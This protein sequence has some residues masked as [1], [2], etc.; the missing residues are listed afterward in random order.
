MNILSVP[1]RLVASPEG[2]QKVPNYLLETER[3]VKLKDNDTFEVEPAV[4]HFSGIKINNTHVQKLRIINR[5]GTQKRVIIVPPETPY[6]SIKY[7]KKTTLRPGLSED[8][9]IEFTPTEYKYYGDSI[10]LFCYGDNNLLIPIHGY[11]SVNNIQF[12]SRV[13]FHNVAISRSITKSIPLSCDIPVEFEFSVATPTPHPFFNVHPLKGVVPANGQTKI[14]VTFTPQDYT[15]ASM[16]L[17]INISQFSF[18]PFVCT[19]S[20]CALPGEEQA[21]ELKRLSEKNLP[22]NDE[23]AKRQ[24][25]ISVKPDVLFDPKML[26]ANIGR[27]LNV[28][29]SHRERRRQKM[30]KSNAFRPEKDPGVELNSVPSVDEFSGIR[31][32]ENLNNMSAVSYCLTQQPGKLKLKE[33]RELVEDRKRKQQKLF[34]DVEMNSIRKTSI[35]PKNK[36]IKEI[37]FQQDIKERSAYERSKGAHWF[38]CTGE[39][40][41]TEDEK[42]MILAQ[43]AKSS[44]EESEGNIVSLYDITEIEPEVK[45]EDSNLLGAPKDYSEDGND[46]A[47]DGLFRDR[48]REQIPT[49]DD[50]TKKQ[51]VIIKTLKPHVKKILDR[52]ETELS[53]VRII[54]DV[55]HIPNHVPTFD[56]YLCDD[57]V[58]R[59]EAIKK[60]RQSVLKVIVR[61][62]MKKKLFMLNQFISQCGPNPTKEQVRHLVDEDYKYAHMAKASGT[63]INKTIG[64]VSSGQV[65]V[66]QAFSPNPDIHSDLTGSRISTR[67]LTRE[68]LSRQM[69]ADA[70]QESVKY[71]N[72]SLVKQFTFPISRHDPLCFD[73][74]DEIEFADRNMEF[75]SLDFHKPKIPLEYVLLGYEE[76]DYVDSSKYV[77][78]MDD[79]PQKNGALDEIAS[80]CDI[81][82]ST[83]QGS[84]SDAYTKEAPMEI[85]YPIN[86]PSL[87]VFNQL[88]GCVNFMPLVTHS[89]ISMEFNFNPMR[90]GRDFL[91]LDK[92]DYVVEDPI[93]LRNV[94]QVNELPTEYGT[95]WKRLNCP[96]LF[97]GSKYPTTTNVWIPRWTNTFGDVMLGDSIPSM[98]HDLPDEDAMSE[99]SDFEDELE[100]NEEGN[101]EQVVRPVPSPSMIEATFYLPPDFSQDELSREQQNKKESE[102]CL[103]ETNQCVLEN[104]IVSRKT[105]DNELNIWITNQL[106]KVGKAIEDREKELHE[107]FKTSLC[108]SPN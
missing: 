27:M 13:D 89:E 76:I 8:I 58:R 64:P 56:T 74:Q 2:E 22:D 71:Y 1:R 21:K 14:D 86:F 79:K 36:Q 23:N 52:R 39:D 50:E 19:F 61:I 94:E 15:T 103:P 4:V 69:T 48:L 17:E 33:L 95:N 66:N 97:S 47:F 107:R 78:K 99:D 83:G 6:F 77:P 62:R 45:E 63:V 51:K 85:F 102:I 65:N 55:H 67:P 32:P 46:G 81:E 90:K 72:T 49:D 100:V 41:I 42:E 35:D 38:I 7:K 12:P 16:S 75:W 10:R 96:A 57:W 37:V 3:F 20:G 28:H 91:H 104:G 93:E 40:E 11:P 105:R 60:F 101:F 34:K 87:H 5:T 68:L 82:K 29:L 26:N 18:V 106:N 9:T 25:G 88:P 31:F 92:F 30:K 98:L 54:R 59:F 24:L 70:E 43:R 73:G 84:L 80:M 53:K 108:G 44:L